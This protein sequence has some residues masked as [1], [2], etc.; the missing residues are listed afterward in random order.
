M[1]T[2]HETFHGTF[3]ESYYISQSAALTPCPG[4]RLVG[5]QLAISL[6]S[7][8]LILLSLCYAVSPANSGQLTEEFS[9]IFSYA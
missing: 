7:D 8:W 4:S 5:W 9:A 2:F 3:H 6:A 1:V